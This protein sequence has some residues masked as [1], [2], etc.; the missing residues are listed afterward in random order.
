VA[1][2][3]GDGEECLKRDEHLPISCTNLLCTRSFETRALMLAHKRGAHG[4]DSPDG[5]IYR[6]AWDDPVTG[7][8]CVSQF[9]RCYDLTRHEESVHARTNEVRCHLCGEHQ[10]FS[11][12][13]ALARHMRRMHSN[14]IGVEELVKR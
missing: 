4:S 3:V 13:D 12:K 14:V 6:C 10:T 11:R 2:V 1:T 8:S 5:A 7:E 9:N